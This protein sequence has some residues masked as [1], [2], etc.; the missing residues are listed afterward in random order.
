MD[1]IGFIVLFARL[2]SRCTV[3]VLLS[4]LLFEIYFVVKHFEGLSGFVKG[5]INKFD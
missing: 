3:F 1:F 5:Y 2:L 4:C